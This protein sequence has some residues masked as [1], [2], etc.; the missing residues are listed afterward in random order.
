MTQT[1]RLEAFAQILD[2]TGAQAAIDLQKLCKFI[3][4][5]GIPPIGSISILADDD[6]SEVAQHDF[7]TCPKELCDFSTL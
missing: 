7:E 3:R 6:E 4:L 1:K 2:L 5:H